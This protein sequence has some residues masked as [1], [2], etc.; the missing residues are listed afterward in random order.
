VA[1]IITLK[2]TKLLSKAS[3]CLKLLLL[4]I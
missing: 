4:K 3:F 2:A 1:L